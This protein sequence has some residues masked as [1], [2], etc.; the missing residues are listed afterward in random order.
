M[1]SLN[2]RKQ[3][4]LILGGILI[5][6]LVLLFVLP[7]PSPP[8]KGFNLDEI[9]GAGHLRVSPS[10][11]PTASASP[12]FKPSGSPSGLENPMIALVLDDNGYNLEQS[13]AFIALPFPF[14]LSVLP[15]LKYSR[16]VAREALSK[17][18][19][20]ILHCPMES[21]EG[22]RWLG[23]G[24][25]LV[26]MSDDE[27]KKQVEADLYDVPGATGV[28]NHMGTKATEDERVMK[29][30][31]SYLKE[32]G[33]YFLDSKVTAGSKASQIGQELGVI[34]LENDLSLDHD[35][36][37][38]VI[39]EN[40]KRLGEI[41][42]KKG[43]AIGIAHVY[44]KNLLPLFKELGDYWKEQGFRLVPLSEILPYFTSSSERK[45]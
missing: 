18:K 9:I 16:Q 6:A 25:I 11:I 35:P 28:N 5:L 21:Y 43:V 17:G 14:T 38:R 42:Q 31:L 19:E 36:D 15:S 24:A 32:R 13:R 33:L 30:F 4:C 41:A 44:T 39:R 40:M 29:A 45:P 23:P 27:I 37:P 26:S 34:V 10:P 7:S 1:K 20:V 22:N 12:S 3:T 8:L 2:S